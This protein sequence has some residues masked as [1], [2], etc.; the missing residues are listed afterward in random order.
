MQFLLHGL[1]LRCHGDDAACCL[2]ASFGCREAIKRH[3]EGVFT[4]K[5]MNLFILNQIVVFDDDRGDGA[6]VV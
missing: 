1:F 6:V 5:Q 3:P 4:M 2:C